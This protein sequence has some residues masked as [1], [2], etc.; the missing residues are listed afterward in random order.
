MASQAR[1]DNTITRYTLHSSYAGIADVSSAGSTGVTIAG[2]TPAIPGTPDS[3][4]RTIANLANLANP[5]MR[6]TCPIIAYAT[7][8]LALHT[9][10][11]LLQKIM[12][13]QKLVN[14]SV[15]AN[16]VSKTGAGIAGGF[17]RGK[18]VPDQ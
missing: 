17:E 6:V 1:V 18:I 14:G 11:G 9:V 10:T 2:E 4:E 3:L 16:V 8:F 15:S 12:Q 5:M 7:V 13:E